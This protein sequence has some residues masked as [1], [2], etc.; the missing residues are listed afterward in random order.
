M[1]A[2]WVRLI[3]T[4]I[5]FGLI[6]IIHFNVYYLTIVIILYTVLRCFTFLYIR[7]FH[8]TEVIKGL[9]SHSGWWWP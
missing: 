8:N 6:F 4:V 3:I 9:K 1:L 2:T 7:I 5:I